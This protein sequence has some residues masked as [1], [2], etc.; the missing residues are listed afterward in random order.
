MTA[1]LP[2]GDGAAVPLGDNKSEERMLLGLGDPPA[3]LRRGMSVEDAEARVLKRCRA[4]RDQMLYAVRLRLRL[5]NRLLRDRPKLQRSISA[6]AMQS[7]TEI[8]REAFGPGEPS[9]SVAPTAWIVAA[10][11][12]WRAYVEAVLDFN[13]KW[14]RFLETFPLDDLHRA[15]DGYNRYYVIEKECAV[16]SARTALRGFV[17]RQPWT[18]DDLLKRFPPLPVPP[19]DHRG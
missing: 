1:R 18:F 13:A 4:A 17:P 8:G 12:Q 15:I 19:A 2:D 3:Y 11:G 6:A 5:W 14:R 7:A 9:A 10:R 16:R